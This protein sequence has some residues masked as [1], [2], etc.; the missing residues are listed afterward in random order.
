M[1][2][3]VAHSSRDGTRSCPPVPFTLS[4]V[5]VP[6]ESRLRLAEVTLTVPD[7]GITA[8]TGP[9][10]AGKSTLLRLCNR[11]IAPGAGRVAYRGTDL[12]ETD[13]LA[14]RRRVGMVF[15]RP[16][17]FA[18][19]VRD[20]LRV[21]APRAPDPALRALLERC[22]LD[23]GMLDRVADTLSGGEQQRMS[24]AR[25][26]ATGPETL[27][28]DEPTSSLDEQAATRLERL[29]AQRADEGVPVLLVSHD[30][31]QVRRL[32]D[33]VVVLDRGRVVREGAA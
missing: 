31:A 11:L 29:I 7:R 24:L 6:G 9:S 19:T 16:V 23:G 17:P 5:S 21:A 3:L 8:V 25:T 22:E 20:N 12:A 33:H 10:G 1:G 27:L 13:P 26:L 15:Q 4:S 32:A 18:G 14:L 28:M 30:A 2:V